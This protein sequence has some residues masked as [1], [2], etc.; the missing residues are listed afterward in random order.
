MTLPAWREERREQPARR[1]PRKVDELDGI[2]NRAESPANQLLEMLRESQLP[3]EAQKKPEPKPFR[4]PPIARRF[5][6]WLLGWSVLAM[7]LSVGYLAYETLTPETAV[8]AER[9]PLDF[10]DVASRYVQSSE[11]PAIE[12]SGLVRNSGETL[13]EPDVLLQLAGSRVAIEEPLRL[14]AAVLPPGAERPFTVRVLLP[15]GTRSVRLLPPEKSGQAMGDL[16][17]VS[18]AWTAAN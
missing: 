12:L 10:A 8:P 7:G 15:E 14:G 4:T 5:A 17:L 3:G 11:G 1:R 16:M 9:P 13:V 18:P 6:K 2:R